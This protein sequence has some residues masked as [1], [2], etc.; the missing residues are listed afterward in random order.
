MIW[1][2]CL[3]QQ[4]KRIICILLSFVVLVSCA[5]P[6]GSQQQKASSKK[7]PQGEES[8][9]YSDFVGQLCTNWNPHTYMTQD[10]AYPQ[11]FIQSSLYGFYFNDKLH[12]VKGKK[13]Y[14]SYVIVPE[15]AAGDPEDVTVSVRASHPQFQIPASADSGFAFRVRL[16]EDL[17]WEDGTPITAENVKRLLVRKAVKH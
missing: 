9:T 15:M 1:S 11:G 17:C 14:E 6:G 2:I 5:A 3:K 13:P 16:R 10:D 8:F 4:W 12:P 7:K